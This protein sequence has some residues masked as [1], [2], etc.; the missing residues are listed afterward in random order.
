MSRL[1]SAQ[2]LTA[3]PAVP[4]DD[5]WIEA[6]DDGSHVLIRPLRAEDRERER[7]FIRRLS[8]ETRHLR[9]LCAIKEASPALLDQ[10]MDVDYRDRMAFVALVHR[11][12][13]L[14]EV[15]V[16]RYAAT[17]EPGHCECAVTVADDWLGRGLGVVLMRHLIDSARN[18]GF[19]RIYSVDAA[20]NAGMQRTARALGFNCRRD[21]HDATQ[22][23]HSLEL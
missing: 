13:E 5:H 6:L 22:V 17:D 4:A 9:F 20:T 23:I 2:P 11:D 21:P 8:P 15:G 19:K 10:L 3:S 1:Q 18:N 14:I 7:E 12:G 16:S